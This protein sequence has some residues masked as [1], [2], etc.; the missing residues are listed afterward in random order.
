MRK[1]GRELCKKLFSEEGRI[2]FVATNVRFTILRRDELE[3]VLERR[4]G[5]IVSERKEE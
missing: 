1:L 5:R 3:W 4:D 2:K